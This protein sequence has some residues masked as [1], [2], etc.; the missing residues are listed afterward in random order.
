M[1]E[2]YLRA[3][4][5]INTTKKITLVHHHL[6]SQFFPYV[7]ISLT[8][9]KILPTLTQISHFPVT[10]QVR[11]RDALILLRQPL[12]VGASVCLVT[13]ISRFT[14]R[15]LSMMQSCCCCCRPHSTNVLPAE[16]STRI[17]WQPTVSPPQVARKGSTLSGFVQRSRLEMDDDDDAVVI[18]TISSGSEI[19]VPYRRH[20]RLLVS[21]HIR[22]LLLILG[23]RWWHKVTHSEI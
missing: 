14:Q 7:G 15:L 2:S 1:S 23:L 18:S 12:A 4:L 16:S 11:S 21:F 8:T 3:G 20:F 10:S 5:I 17:M 19:W 6:M 9:Q 13:I 22:R